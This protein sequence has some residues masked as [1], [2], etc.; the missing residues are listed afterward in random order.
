MTKYILALLLGAAV[1]YILST[2]GLTAH[3]WQFCS[4]LGI[5]GMTIG[6]GEY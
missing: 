4:T 6:F 3:D 5:L 1:S 2:A